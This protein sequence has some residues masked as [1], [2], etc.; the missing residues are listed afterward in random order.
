[1]SVRQKVAA[2]AN[3]ILAVH[4]SFCVKT[5]MG[6][7][8][9]PRKKLEKVAFV[10]N[11][12]ITGTDKVGETEGFAGKIEKSGGESPALGKKGDIPFWGENVCERGVEAQGR[13]EE[14]Q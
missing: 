3:K 12:L 7:I 13:M 8:L 11:G 1:M 4:H 9:L 14:A 6:D 10:Q 5:D 2:E